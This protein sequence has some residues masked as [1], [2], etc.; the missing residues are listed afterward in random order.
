[1]WSVGSLWKIHVWM[2]CVPFSMYI[3]CCKKYILANMRYVMTLG[4][5][6]FSI[7]ECLCKTHSMRNETKVNNT[8]KGRVLKLWVSAELHNM[9]MILLLCINGSF[10]RFSSL[11]ITHSTSAF[12][13]GT[14]WYAVLPLFLQIIKKDCQNILKLLNITSK[15]HDL[16]RKE[17]M[18]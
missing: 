5:L 16:F 8:F 10:G 12:C 14:H 6:H 13:G 18:A 7:L 15:Y 11:W 4:T 2:E 1:M 9:S 3:L 17:S